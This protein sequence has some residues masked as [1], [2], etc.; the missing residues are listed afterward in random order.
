M[1]IILR[2]SKKLCIFA[3]ILNIKNIMKVL[4]IISDVLVLIS[5]IIT[6]AL[7][8]EVATEDYLISLLI[9]LFLLVFFLVSGIFTTIYAFKKK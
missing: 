7:F 4:A 1:Q 2:I 8:G 5:L 3:K 9:I 6:M